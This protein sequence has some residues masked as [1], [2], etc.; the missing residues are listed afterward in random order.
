[1]LPESDIFSFGA[2]VQSIFEPA[3]EP[4]TCLIAVDMP[5][6][7]QGLVTRC[8]ARNPLERPDFPRIQAMLRNLHVG[9]VGAA[10]VQ[11]GQ[12]G[13]RQDR[14]LQ[15]V[16]LHFLPCGYSSCL[17]LLCLAAAFSTVIVRICL[18]CF[19]NSMLLLKL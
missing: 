6:A 3:L 18:Y 12:E 1:M 10:F 11:R 7:L 4:G 8:Q 2:L 5:A 14:V 17:S 16:R 9:T 19:F 15:Q 13:R